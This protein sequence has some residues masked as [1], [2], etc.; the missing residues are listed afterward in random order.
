MFKC[1][2]RSDEIHEGHRNTEM[3]SELK[4]QMATDLKDEKTVNND[5]ITEEDRTKTREKW[6]YVKVNMDG[7]IVGRKICILYNGGYSSLALQ[8]EDMFGKIAQTNIV[9]FYNR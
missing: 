7:V 3:S 2:Q 1:Y 9:H 8:L 4:P 5:H 6:T